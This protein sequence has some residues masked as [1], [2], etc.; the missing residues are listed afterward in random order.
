MLASA[1]GIPRHQLS[2]NEQ[3]NIATD[4]VVYVPGPL[5]EVWAIQ[6][7]LGRIGTQH[8]LSIRVLE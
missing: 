8:Y 1:D 3:K 7:C 5:N 2:A 6:V 4:G